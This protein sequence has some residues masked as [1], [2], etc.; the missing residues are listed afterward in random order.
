MPFILMKKSLCR[1]LTA[2]L[3]SRMSLTLVIPSVLHADQAGTRT[4]FGILAGASKNGGAHKPESYEF[5]G[6]TDR[7]GA[8]VQ[9][10]KQKDQNAP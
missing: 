3:A 6:K 5:H 1:Y 10:F 2:I 4:F 9:K 8:K 7:T